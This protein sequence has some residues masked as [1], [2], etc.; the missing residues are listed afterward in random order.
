MINPNFTAFDVNYCVSVNWTLRKDFLASAAFM[1]E[2]K[3]KW[4]RGKM[5]KIF[6]HYV[7]QRG[8]KDGESKNFQ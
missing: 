7:I 8:D 3:F 5:E 2:Q 4:D 6:I 1:A